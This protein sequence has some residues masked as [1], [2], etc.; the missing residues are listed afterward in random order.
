MDEQTKVTVLRSI[1]RDRKGRFAKKRK[2]LW[3]WFALA[4]FIG[5]MLVGFFQ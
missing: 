1:N 5:L 3:A 4:A 2:P